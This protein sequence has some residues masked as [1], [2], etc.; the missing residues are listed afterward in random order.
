MIIILVVLLLLIVYFSRLL[1]FLISEINGIA[2]K[3]LFLRF[4]M[5]LS[6][7]LILDMHFDG[8]KCS[9]ALGTLSKGIIGH[10]SKHLFSS[11]F[12]LLQNSLK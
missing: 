2:L 12:D 8:C 4:L 7:S 6:F 5:P 11:Y 9:F 10:V 1:S 3:D